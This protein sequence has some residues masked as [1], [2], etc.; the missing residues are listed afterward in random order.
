MKY[1]TMSFDDGL[2]QDKE[3]IKVMEQAGL[4]CCT[5]NLN[6]GLFGQRQAIGR[7]GKF[8]FLPK[9]LKNGYLPTDQFLIKYHNNFRIPADEIPEVYKNVEVAAHGLQHLNLKNLSVE[10]LTKEIV[11][12]KTQLESIF[13]R[14]VQGYVFAFGMSSKA[15]TKVISSGGFTYTRGIRNTRCF[16]FPQDPL[17]L[18]PTCSHFNKHIFDLLDS[19]IQK[20]TEEDQLFYIWGH[21]Y[22]LD[23]NTGGG[24]YE[25]LKRILDKVARHSEIICCSNA[26][27]LSRRKSS[28]CYTVNA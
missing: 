23:F 8:G 3:I 17:H 6:S 21:G 26:A 14:E 12:D 19:F 25:H 5:F 15:A 1:F 13:H 18:Q 16:D 2:E 7:I 11:G 20:E 9:P 22:E 27:A 4:N 24:T 28:G 10:R